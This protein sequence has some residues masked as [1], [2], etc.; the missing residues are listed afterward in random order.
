MKIHK[1]VGKTSGFISPFADEYDSCCKYQRMLQNAS[2]L[3]TPKAAD[4]LEL[5]RRQRDKLYLFVLFCFNRFLT[6]LKDTS[7][8]EHPPRKK[9]SKN[10]DVDI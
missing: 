1:P 8:R 5:L 2:D 9:F 10:L 6:R 3:S 4:F 7:G